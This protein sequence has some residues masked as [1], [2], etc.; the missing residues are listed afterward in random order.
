MLVKG[1][2]DPIILQGYFTGTEPMQ[3]IYS[4]GTSEATPSGIGKEIIYISYYKYG[5]KEIKQKE[6]NI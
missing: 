6:N 2:Q 5:I 1:G 3:S 4:P